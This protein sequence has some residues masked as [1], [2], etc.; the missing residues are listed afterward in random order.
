MS[1]FLRQPKLRFT[2]VADA[3][4]VLKSTV[5]TVRLAVQVGLTKEAQHQVGAA[6]LGFLRKLNPRGSAM[7]VS[8][9]RYSP[10]W[11]TAR[12]RMISAE[13]PPIAITFVSR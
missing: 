13:P 7:C 4:R 2:V 1:G 10:I 8:P 6:M 12:S 5:R 9:T 11:R 3:R